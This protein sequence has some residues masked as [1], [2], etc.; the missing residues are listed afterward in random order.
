[1][2]RTEDIELFIAHSLLNKVLK[3]EVDYKRLEK[4][5]TVQVVH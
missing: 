2:Q 4:A 3:S 1:M 5:E